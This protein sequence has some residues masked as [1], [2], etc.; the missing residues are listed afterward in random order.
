MTETLHGT[1]TVD[2]TMSIES[3][4]ETICI[5]GTRLSTQLGI[6]S[7]KWLIKRRGK[8]LAAIIK[9]MVEMPEDDP[10][11]L[12]VTDVLIGL[13]LQAQL[14]ADEPPD[15]QAAERDI[16]KMSFPDM[17]EAYRRARPFDFEAK[18]S[19]APEATPESTGPASSTTSA[20]SSAGRPTRSKS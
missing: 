2:D 16:D 7:V 4:Y 9:E 13:R 10:D 1:D 6:G 12:L 20:G 8:S 18:N 19:P 5:A 17:Q 3:K 15:T 11:F 14:L